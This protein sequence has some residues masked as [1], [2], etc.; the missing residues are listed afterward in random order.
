MFLKKAAVKSY[1]LLN[2]RDIDVE[3]EAWTAWTLWEGC[4]KF[5]S[6]R[7]LVSQFC[8]EGRKIHGKKIK[9]IT[10]MLHLFQYFVNDSQL[11]RHG[12]SFKK[13]TNYF[14]QLYFEKCEG[15]A[16]I[17]YRC[18]TADENSKVRWSIKTLKIVTNDH[19]V[20][21]RLFVK[22]LDSTLLITHVRLIQTVE[23]SVS[24]SFSCWAF[25]VF[26]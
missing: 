12:N 2:V 10:V 11:E 14:W 1:T 9:E 8:W 22:I 4:C 18:P 6:R 25:L 20:L 26:T 13:C 5:S 17:W 7:H 21:R 23:Y 19:D 24:F 16:S 15:G 3:T